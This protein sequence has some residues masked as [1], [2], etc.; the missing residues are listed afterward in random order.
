MSTVRKFAEGQQVRVAKPKQLTRRISGSQ[1]VLRQP[2]PDDVAEVVEV[3]NP[4][5]DMP[6]QVTAEF[7]VDGKVIWNAEF[8]ADELALA[9][10]HD[11]YQDGDANIPAAICDRNGDVAL[12]MCKRCGRAEVEL[13]EP[14]TRKESA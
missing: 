12:G 4:A 1:G 2:K 13:S 7:V 3:V 9:H 6:Q 8:T 5:G 14:C 10:E 11:L